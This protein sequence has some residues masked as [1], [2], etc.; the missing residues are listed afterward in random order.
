MKEITIATIAICI[1]TVVDLGALIIDH[2][3]N[4]PVDTK[5]MCLDS[6]GIPV[7]SAWDSR[8]TDCIK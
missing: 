4:P 6:G 8:L 5:Q 2:Y 3:V 7:V 1:I